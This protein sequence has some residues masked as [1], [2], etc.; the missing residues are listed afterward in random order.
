[1][2][3]EAGAHFSFFHA[4]KATEV[5]ADKKLPVNRLQVYFSFRANLFISLFLSLSPYDFFFSFLDNS[6]FD[7]RSKNP[8]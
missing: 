2:W 6:S 8:V 7:S 5:S 1:M 4:L 3:R